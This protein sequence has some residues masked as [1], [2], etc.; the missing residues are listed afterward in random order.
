M[1]Y[2]MTDPQF[3][4]IDKFCRRRFPI[5]LK[6]ETREH[7][8]AVLIASIEAKRLKAKVEKT[9]LGLTASEIERNTV[10]NL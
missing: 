6:G 3:P 8:G 5:D 1:Q 10:E 4:L 7:R 9:E 2:F